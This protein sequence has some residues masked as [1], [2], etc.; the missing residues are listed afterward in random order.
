MPMQFRRAHAQA[1]LVVT[2]LVVL[3]SVGVIGTGAAQAAPSP[4]PTSQFTSL[5]LGSRHVRAQVV[6]PAHERVY[7]ATATGSSRKYQLSI[8]D[9]TTGEQ[10]AAVALQHL[11]D[12][13]MLDA[14]SHTLFIAETDQA[15]LG[16]P[17]TIAE[18]DIGTGHIVRTIAAGRS[19]SALAMADGQVFASQVWDGTVQVRDPISGSLTA[20]IPVGETPYHMAADPAQHRLY[21]LN[22]GHYSVGQGYGASTVSVVDTRS[23]QVIDTYQAGAS[24]SGVALNA[25]TGMLYVSAN[26]AQ[27]LKLDAV[28]GIQVAAAQTPS[29]G[30]DVA[31]DPDTNM[32]AVQGWG[33]SVWLYDSTTLDVTAQ[34]PAEGAGT[35]LAVDRQNHLLYVGSS[36]LIGID[37][38]DDTSGA[39]RSVIAIGFTPAAVAVDSVTHA[40]YVVT[41]DSANRGTVLAINSAA[42]AIVRSIPVGKGPFAAAINPTTHTLY[43]LN[44]ADNTVSVVNT[45]TGVVT[46]QILVGAHPSAAALD[47][48]QQR[49]YVT[50]RDDS[51]ASIINLATGTVT[52]TVAV[53]SAPTSVSV[54]EARNIAFVAN[55][56]GNTVSVISGLTNTVTATFADQGANLVAV[57]PVSHKVFVGGHAAGS[58][59]GTLAVYDETSHAVLQ[60]FGVF[61]A[62]H[63]LAV[64]GPGHTLLFSYG[65]AFSVIDTVDYQFIPGA[66]TNHFS[67]MV[68]DQS[69]HRAYL[70][71]TSDGTLAVYAYGMSMRVVTQPVN[72]SV[73]AGRA[74]TVSAR[75]TGSPV[76][77]VC[78]EVLRKGSVIWQML[79]YCDSVSALVGTYR[80]APA[81]TD[82]QA[83]SHLEGPRIVRPAMRGFRGPAP[84]RR[85]CLTDRSATRLLA[86]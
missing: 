5:D 57:D 28:T 45:A 41:V 75:V 46:G 63:S 39:V 42:T 23:Y 16:S 56:A 6:D 60:T 59:Q 58:S 61:S 82:I 8:V 21:V 69:T 12:A 17:S 10:V 67:G 68:I 27:L 48:T 1:V 72:L 38:L 29:D 50:N 73:I 54:D 80:L 24:A 25:V 31:V 70:S 77:T 84:A 13:L 49:L 65:S 19:L 40:A 62:P 3:A 15:T 52:A 44:A 34:V 85:R 4:Y 9:T 11:S 71:E 32:V 2:A 64:D 30:N 51:D 86:C 35:G 53:G 18:L 37:V 81:A 76:P 26:G 83:G 33:H 78:G 66:T 47:V 55:S 74:F 79:P 14:A 7:F 20:T 22:T 43:V 36:N